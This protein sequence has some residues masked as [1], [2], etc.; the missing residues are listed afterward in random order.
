[1]CLVFVFSNPNVR[2][3]ILGKLLSTLLNRGDFIC[4]FIRS[5]IFRFSRG[6]SWKGETRNGEVLDSIH[7]LP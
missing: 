3:R 5:L 4:L 1:M 2:I 6:E 7:F